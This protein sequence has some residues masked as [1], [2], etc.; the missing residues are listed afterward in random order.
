MEVRKEPVA[1]T[2]R[3]EPVAG[4]VATTTRVEAESMGAAES[5]ETDDE[6]A[7]GAEEEVRSDMAVDAEIREEVNERRCARRDPLAELLFNEADAA[8]VDDESRARL[9][10]TL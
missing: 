6:E 1:V 8:S 10:R 3:P 4:A 9:S 5:S 2:V 7:K